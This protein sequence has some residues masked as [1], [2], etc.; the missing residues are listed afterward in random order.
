MAMVSGLAATNFGRAVSETADALDRERQFQQARSDRRTELDARLEAKLEEI[1]LR[2]GAT[3][4]RYGGQTARAP[5]YSDEERAALGDM[6]LPEFAEGRQYQITGKLPQRPAFTTDDEGRPFVDAEGKPMAPMIEE[7]EARPRLERLAAG[8]RRSVVAGAVDPQHLDD[9]AAG[10]EAVRVQRDPSLTPEERAKRVAAM[11]GA[12]MRDV[13]G[14]TTFDVFTGAGEI[15]ERGQA[16]SEAERARAVR[17]PAAAGRAPNDLRE[18]NT[19]V[20]TARRT[21]KDATTAAMD[22]LLRNNPQALGMDAREREA[23]LANNTRV[24]RAQEEL[25]RALRYR[26]ELLQRSPGGVRLPAGET[27]DSVIAQARA[28]IARGARRDAVVQRLES[29]GVRDHGL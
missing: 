15:T 21:L 20:E 9:F 2:Y 24:Q 17:A 7:Y 29:W 19:M 6:T 10:F 8:Y 26:N 14:D 27:R 3:A 28:A 18:A 25:D 23:Y 4:R 13:R 5:E 16:R 11:R 12:R 1:M 22:A